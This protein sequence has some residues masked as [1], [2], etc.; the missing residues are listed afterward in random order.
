VRERDVEGAPAGEAV[1]GAEPAQE[2]PRLAEPA[3][4]AVP[5]PHDVMRNAVQLEQLECL[6]VL[7]SRHDDLVPLRLEQGDQRLEERHVR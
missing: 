2:R 4:P 1:E 7:A 6:G 5:R 3:R